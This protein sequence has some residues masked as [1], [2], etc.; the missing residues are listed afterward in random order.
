M[1]LPSRG[2][3]LSV[4]VFL[5]LLT[6]TPALAQN[7]S[8]DARRIAIGGVGSTSN[9]ALEIVDEQRPYKAIVLPFG[10]FQILPN[11]PKLDPTK[12]EFDLVRAIEY[13]ASPIH[14]IIGRDD[15]NTASA[16][17]TDL[18][19]GELS[20][21]LNVY[22]GFSPATSVAA[23]GLASPS[24]GYTFKFKKD[25]NGSF[26]GV[27]AGAGPY[28][29]MKTA[30]EIDP[31]LAAVFASPTPVF[32]PNTSFYM[33]NNTESQFALAI[34]GGYRGRF[35]WSG[36]LAGG[37]TGP[38]EGN[39]AAEGLYIGANVHFLKGFN[40]QHFQP[41]ARLDTNAQGLLVVNPALGF[42]VTITR[43]DSGSGTGIAADV[44]AAGIIGRWEFGLGVNGIGNHMDWTNVERTSYVL[45]SLFNS[46]E[47]VDF[48]SI[49]VD[50]VRV[51][52]PVDVRGNASYDAG[53]WMAITEFGHGFNGGSLRLGYEHRLARVQ[54]RGGA[55][56]IKERWEPTGGGGYN[57]TDHFG[58]DVGLFSTSAN[59]ERQRHL[60][61]AVSLR[62]MAKQKN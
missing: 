62:L 60:A 8:F 32:I 33:S 52:L 34:T 19:N 39:M 17:I 29:S 48:P 43:T 49:P 26:Q 4:C 14:F 59:L 3:V 44:G 6:S 28:F 23:E 58:V 45:D 10:L 41:A 35:A 1:R 57:F 38:S 9:V 15:T 40:Y 36:A 51:K 61:I 53:P 22:R 30:A 7:W 54:L 13:A 2:T 37:S 24:W 47:F 56:Y 25:P 21:D 5:S 42:P 50:D 20:R 11:M 18:R 12:D 16:F 55:R 27:Y 46:G 31:A